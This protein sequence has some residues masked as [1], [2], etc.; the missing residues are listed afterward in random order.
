MQIVARKDS[1]LVFMIVHRPDMGKSDTGGVYQEG[2]GDGTVTLS[3]GEQFIGS[4][5]LQHGWARGRR[6]AGSDER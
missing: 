3:A 2:N 4:E 1:S 5:T 6:R